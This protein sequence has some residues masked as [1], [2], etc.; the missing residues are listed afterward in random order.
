MCRTTVIAGFA[1]AT[2][3]TTVAAKAAVAEAYFQLPA[4]DENPTHK[5]C[6]PVLC[7]LS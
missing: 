5:R 1:V 4:I 6:M 2:N 7:P 3:A